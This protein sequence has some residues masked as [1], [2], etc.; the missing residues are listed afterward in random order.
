[1]SQHIL[2]EAYEHSDTPKEVIEALLTETETD[3][4]ARQFVF[5]YDR[6]QRR[7]ELD[8]YSLS[9]FELKC[10]DSVADA[11]DLFVQRC[12]PL[13]TN[14]ET[15]MR[16]AC[17]ARVRLHKMSG[18]PFYADLGEFLEAFLTELNTVKRTPA[19]EKL[20]ISIIDLLEELNK[21]VLASVSGRSCSGLHGCSLYF[22]T[23]HIDSSYS[24]AFVKEHT[25][26]SFLERF[27][28]HS[29]TFP[30]RLKVLAG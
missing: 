7:R 4:T 22:P 30:L 14:Q 1:M 5:G 23:S 17:A 11:L 16:A 10:L 20:T 21:A 25:W 9:V 19:L 3:H 26:R 13:L 27:T 24:G 28:G 15:V 12:I 2:V 18:L 29:T 6:V 8:R